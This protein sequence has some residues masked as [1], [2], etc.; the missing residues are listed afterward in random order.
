MIDLTLHPKTLEK[1]IAYC[2]EKGITLPT[3]DMMK[4]PEKVPDKIKAQLEATGLWDLHPANL[5]RI[6]WNNEPR[7]AGGLFGDVNHFLLPPELTGCK[8]TI[9][10]LAGRWF[11]TGAHKVGATFGC[12]APTL[13][14]GQ[15][16]PQKTKAV[17][18]STG[19][20]CRG[21]AYISALLACNAIAI[22]PEEMSRERF[23][24][25]SQVAGQVIATP[26]CESNV[27]EIF[28]KCWELRKSGEDL[29]I[30]NQFDEMGNPLWHYA[31]TGNAVETLLG[32][33]LTEGKRFAG[34][35]SSSGSGGTL[36]AGYYLKQ[37][38]PRSKLVAAEAL[39]CPTLLYNG[40]GA[41]RI[42]GI[43]DKHVPWVHDCKET[44]FAVGVDDEVPMR[45]LR[46]FNES[47]GRKA[48]VA[49]GVDERLTQQLDLLG[50]SGIGNLVAAIKFAKYNELTEDDIVVSIATDSM[51]LYGSR[52]SELE[53]ER[54]AYTDAD[55]Q[56][57]IEL[58]NAIAIDHT[59]EL[60]YYD[61]KTVHNLKYY[62]WIEQQAKE[63]DELNAQWYDHHEYWG[64]I[65]QM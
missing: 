62:T 25:L 41:H 17:W 1:N 4:H 43:G 52:L 11:P 48:L 14:T 55:A 63:L 58:I 53:Q 31:V 39:Q 47:V 12:L 30:F 54:G 56:R 61:R 44:D 46:L 57:D 50:I 8:A 60:S 23:E 26:G 7:D 42:E 9:I 33:Y 22:L 5:Y 64:S 32:Q 6:T 37:K 65:H 59:K 2:R 28:D 10:M 18:P 3:F 35:V 24:W 49:N 21:G 36:G 51:Q 19:N 34:Y 15:F 13:V 38:F 27:K 20:Y 40:F 29:R 45:A 16:D